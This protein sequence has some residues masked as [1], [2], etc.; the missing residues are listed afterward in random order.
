MNSTASQEPRPA[1]HF[2]QVERR[3]PESCDPSTR[4]DRRANIVPLPPVN[5]AQT[6]VTTAT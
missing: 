3:P 6:W 4:Q 5:D 1:A 2:A